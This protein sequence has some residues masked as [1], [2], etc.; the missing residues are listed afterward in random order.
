[1]SE[2]KKSKWQSFKEWTA[3]FV[4]RLFVVLGAL[5]FVQFPLFVTQYLQRL[6]GHVA[7]LK[8]QVAKM[9]QAAAASNL[10][11]ASYIEKFVQSGDT[12]VA[13]Q[14]E[15]MQGMADRLEALS[16]ALHSLEGASSLTRPFLFLWHF[17]GSIFCAACSGYSFGVP[18]TFEGAIWAVIGAFAGYGL[19]LLL[20][21]LFRRRNGRPSGG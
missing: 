11:L 3:K 16:S 17:D 15:L 9:G 2:K 4:D 14:G 19:Y 5:L 10:K 7:E 13:R 8:Y 12:E 21:A 18:F 20:A 1:M 6:G